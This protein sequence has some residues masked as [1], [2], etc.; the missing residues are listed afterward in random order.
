MMVEPLP[1]AVKLSRGQYAQRLIA[2]R[3]FNGAHG[4]RLVR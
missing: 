2:T 3:P 4:I 1:G